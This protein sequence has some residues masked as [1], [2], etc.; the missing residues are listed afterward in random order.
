MAAGGAR[1]LA[2]QCPARGAASSGGRGRFEAPGARLQR[3]RGRRGA[4]S[5]GW[6]LGP[7]GINPPAVAPGRRLSAGEPVGPERKA[8]WG[9]GCAPGHPAPLRLLQREE[10][11]PGAAALATRSPLSAGGSAGGLRLRLAGI[12]SVQLSGA[13]AR[14]IDR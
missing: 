4:S 3:G 5:V 11:A 2:S 1:R 14:Q 8:L 10:G 12:P 7:L 13:G 6:G 9:A